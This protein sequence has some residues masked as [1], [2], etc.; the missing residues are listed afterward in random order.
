MGYSQEEIA[1]IME[2][3][4]STIKSRLYSPLSRGSRGNARAA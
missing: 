1:E 2:C 4:V 3:P